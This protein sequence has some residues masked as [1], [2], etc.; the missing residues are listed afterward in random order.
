[1]GTQLRK[2]SLNI[3]NKLARRM[4]T[5]K[6]CF[7]GIM[8]TCQDLKNQRFLMVI[9]NPKDLS[10]CCERSE[11]IEILV[12]HQNKKFR[13]RRIEYF[14]IIKSTQFPRFKIKIFIYFLL[15]GGIMIDLECRSCGYKFKNAKITPRCPY[16]SKE[17]SV[18]L[19]KTAQDLLNETLGETSVMDEE[20]KRRN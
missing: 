17:G 10:T 19:R 18:G 11:R 9:E 16:C 2:V 3:F 8:P 6:R 7:S 12:Y 15:Q 5:N 1:M 13:R 4:R 14:K 20:R